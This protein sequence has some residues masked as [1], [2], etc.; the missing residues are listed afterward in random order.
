[1]HKLHEHYKE[2]E[3]ENLKH[4][5]AVKNAFDVDAEEAKLMKHF[6]SKK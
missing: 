1:M 6:W 4:R 5:K 2:P 3:V